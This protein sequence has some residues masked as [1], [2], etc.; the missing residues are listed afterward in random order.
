MIRSYTK[1][2]NILAMVYKFS[3]MQKQIMYVEV[4][5]ARITFHIIVI[6]IIIR[7]LSVT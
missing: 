5:V 2:L 3:R 7:G 4:H 6:I 1:V